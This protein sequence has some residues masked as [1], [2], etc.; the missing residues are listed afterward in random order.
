MAL[1]LN[2]V[3]L[4]GNVGKKPEI[5]TMQD[6][7]EMAFFSI[8]TSQ[9]WHDKKTKE[10]KT[11]TEWHK[12]VVFQESLVKIVKSYVE[13]GSRVFVEGHLRTRNWEDSRGIERSVTEVV[14]QGYEA[15]LLL[16]N[17]KKAESPLQE[18][19]D[20]EVYPLAPEEEEELE[21]MINDKV[22]N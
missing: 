14:L 6:G 5:R 12:I 2:K 4:I 18:T 17:A 7:K 15:I 20:T 8:A 10:K 16:L 13:E 22:G 11:R 1:S 19:H 3:L 21:K 9:G